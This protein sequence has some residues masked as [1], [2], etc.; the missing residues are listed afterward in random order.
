[1]D[2]GVGSLVMFHLFVSSLDLFTVLIYAAQ[3]GGQDE[4]NNGVF[5]LSCGD[6]SYLNEQE[7]GCL[8]MLLARTFSETGLCSDI[9]YFEGTFS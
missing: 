4:Y 9:F 1:M 6:L 3:K 5:L 8:S 7:E 2:I